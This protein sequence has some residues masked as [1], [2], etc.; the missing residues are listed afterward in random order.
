MPKKQTTAQFR[1]NLTPDEELKALLER[2]KGSIDLD[3]IEKAVLDDLQR[4]SWAY[5]NT[6]MSNDK[7]QWP[8]AVE[9]VLRQVHAALFSE[10][11]E[12]ALARREAEELQAQLR[13][14]GHEVKLLPWQASDD[15]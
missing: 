10:R 1:T 13:T 9:P 5:G 11:I 15:E 12:K 8:H 6:K 2:I 14:H 7:V 3:P 4:I